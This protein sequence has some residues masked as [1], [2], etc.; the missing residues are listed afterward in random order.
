MIPFSCQ[1]I[2]GNMILIKDRHSFFFSSNVTTPSRGKYDTYKGSTPFTAL[3]KQIR[4][5]FKGNMILIKDRHSVYSFCFSLKKE[6]LGN[7]ILIKDRHNQIRIVLLCILLCLGK[8][9][10]YKGSTRMLFFICELLLQ[11]GKYDT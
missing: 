6:F 7:M 9:D 8:Y 4:M 5:S 3:P 10:T 11:L 1:I 2:G